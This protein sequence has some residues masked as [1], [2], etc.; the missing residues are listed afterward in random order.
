MADC[1]CNTFPESL[2]N[3]TFGAGVVTQSGQGLSYCD[4]VTDK[5]VAALYVDTALNRLWV[6]VGS[7]VGEQAW[8]YVELA[9]PPPC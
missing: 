7:G 9:T 5:P 4:P 3:I 1:T 8:K 6:K 2:G